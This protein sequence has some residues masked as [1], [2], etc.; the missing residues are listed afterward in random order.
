[1]STSQTQGF[2]LAATELGMASAAWLYVDEAAA[3][4][5]DAGVQMLRDELGRHWPI[6]DAICAARQNGTARPAVRL[7]PLRPYLATARRVV[8]VGYEADWMDA[9]VADAPA[10]L[11]FGWLCQDVAPHHRDRM[12]SNHGESVTPL[13]LNDFQT[14][15]GADSILMTY[16]YGGSTK[17]I[18][19]HPSWLRCAGTD[20]RMQFRDL[21]GWQILDVPIEVY[22]RRLVAADRASLTALLPPA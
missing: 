6:L 12:L 1:M 3:S 21:L 18:F 13:T 14:W 17:E 15:A 11:K 19:V 8:V 22:P 16:V 10:T 5:G 9:L 2:Q 7:D 20:V 4:L